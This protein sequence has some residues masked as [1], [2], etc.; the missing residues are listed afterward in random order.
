MPDPLSRVHIDYNLHARGSAFEYQVEMTVR[1][2]TAREFDQFQLDAGRGD[3]RLMTAMW[4]RGGESREE[5]GKR[6]VETERK[7]METLRSMLTDEQRAEMDTKGYFQV[8]GSAGHLYRININEGYQGNVRWIGKSGR[9][10]AE[11]CCHPKGMRGR[12]LDG[13]IGSLPKADAFLA[14][15]LMIEA[16]EVRFLQTTVLSRG[17]MPK[18]PGF[19]HVENTDRL[20]CICEGCNAGRPS[21]DWCF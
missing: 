8:R 12:D 13:A 19:E 11:F 2:M 18:I 1:G 10:K 6:L 9:K 3:Y 5:Q 20:R 16:D 7:A 14:Q 17:N 21:S 15:K 4:E